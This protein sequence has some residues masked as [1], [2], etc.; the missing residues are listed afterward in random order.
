L[1]KN[2]AGEITVYSQ[3]VRVFILEHSFASK[4][5]SAVREAFSNAYL[6]KE[7]P[8]KT[9]IHRLVTEFRAQE[10]FVCSTSDKTAENTVVTKVRWLR[11]ICYAV[12]HNLLKSLVLIFQALPQCMLC[13]NRLTAS[14]WFD[15]IKQGF[16]TISRPKAKFTLAYRLTGSKVI[17]EDNLLKLQRKKERNENRTPA[18]VRNKD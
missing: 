11:I 1:R 16:S 12:P 10:V 18:V 7:V 8:N 13:I 15:C 17:N 9:T 6:D 14:C 3:A 2:C 4:Q 5:F